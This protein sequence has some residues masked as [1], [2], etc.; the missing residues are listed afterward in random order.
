MSTEPDSF[1]IRTIQDILNLPTP[2]HVERCV[3]SLGEFLIHARAAFDLVNS[4]AENVTGNTDPLF[5]LPDGFEWIDDGKDDITEVFHTP[6]GEEG[7]R[8]EVRS[9]H[10]H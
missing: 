4:V 5:P 1:K 7:L 8:I 3:A 9:R 10:E 2:E 6:D